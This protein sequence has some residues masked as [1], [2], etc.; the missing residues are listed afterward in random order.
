MEH[1]TEAQIKLIF[2]TLNTIGLNVRINGNIYVRGKNNEAIY[3][4]M[5]IMY[6]DGIYEV[7]EY[8]A[9]KQEN[10]LHIFTKTKSLILAL[11]SLMK[12]NRKRKIIEKW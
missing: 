3:H 11:K 1:L 7:S 6:E 5:Q 10:E 4:G 2:N 9:G 8:M 12:G